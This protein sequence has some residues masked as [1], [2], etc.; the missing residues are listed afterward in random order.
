MTRFE[1]NKKYTTGNVGDAEMLVIKRTGKYLLIGWP[2]GE[3]KWVMHRE[4]ESSE[5]AKFTGGM[6][7]DA[8]NIVEDAGNEAE[9]FSIKSGDVVKTPR[10]LKVKIHKVFKS[11]NN[12]RKQGYTVTTHYDNSEYGILGKN[13][14]ENRMQFAAYTK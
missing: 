5:Y 13:I 12:A 7:Y 8:A 3:V 11:E 10:F 6:K 4:G 9:P 2:E 1:E 14:G